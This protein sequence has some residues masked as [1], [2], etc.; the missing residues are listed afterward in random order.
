[1]NQISNNN[2]Y[3]KKTIELTFLISENDTVN[4]LFRR[5]YFAQFVDFFILHL[6]L[7][8]NKY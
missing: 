1:M 8:V 2:L 7:D 4:M 3:K 5:A 6:M